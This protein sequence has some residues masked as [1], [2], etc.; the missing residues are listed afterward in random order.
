MP[1]KKLVKKMLQEKFK[2]TLRWKICSD[3]ISK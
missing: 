1:R 2:V 3:I